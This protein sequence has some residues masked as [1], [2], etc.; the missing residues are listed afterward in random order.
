MM[1]E[2]EKNSQ[3]SKRLKDSIARCGGIE[4]WN[5]AVVDALHLI[6]DS[7]MLKDEVCQYLWPESSYP[8]AQKGET[9]EEFYRRK[10]G[11][12]A[13]PPLCVPETAIRQLEP[14][15]RELY[16]ALIRQEALIEA[17]N[18]GVETMQADVARG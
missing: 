10:V 9:F 11:E 17:H 8:T 6:S 5:K 18:L 13:P 12:C 14:I 7:R 3:A 1:T 4:G 15:A 16:D 2:E